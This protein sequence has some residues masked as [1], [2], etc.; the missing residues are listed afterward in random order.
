MSTAFRQL[1]FENWDFARTPI[2]PYLLYLSE[3]FNLTAL[4]NFVFLNSV[5]IFLSMALLIDLLIKKRPKSKRPFLIVV[6]ALLPSV[7]VYQH[8]LLS[9]ASLIF[10]MT[11]IFWISAK[12][13]STIKS[14][15]IALTIVMIVAYYVKPHFKYYAIGVFLL[16]LIVN[17]STFRT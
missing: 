5:L 13:W 15:Y 6:G 1:K 10:L 16:N 9:E 11:V 3:R 8:G 2:F 12:E 14:K 17:K 4:P 7:V